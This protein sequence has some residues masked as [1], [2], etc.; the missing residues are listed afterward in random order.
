MQPFYKIESEWR[1]RQWLS[2]GL[3]NFGPYDEEDARIV[4][5]Y[6][7]QVMGEWPS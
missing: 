7:N 4:D 6:A 5:E 1:I 3:L 2:G